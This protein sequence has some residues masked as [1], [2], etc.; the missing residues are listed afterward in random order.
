MYVILNELDVR[1]TPDEF[2]VKVV[3]E[4]D[5]LRLAVLVITINPRRENT[6]LTAKIVN[7]VHPH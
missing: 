6:N 2:Y 1:E 5:D 3:C 4:I 7:G